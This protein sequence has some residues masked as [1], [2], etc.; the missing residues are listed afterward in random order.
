MGDGEV[1][2]PALSGRRAGQG[3]EDVAGLAIGVDSAVEVAHRHQ[4]VAQ[5]RV[6]LGEVAADRRI[7]IGRGAALGPVA[8]RVV[9]VARGGDV[10]GRLVEEPEHLQRRQPPVGML[11]RKRGVARLVVKRQRLLVV[12]DREVVAQR[13]ARG[14]AA[15]QAGGGLRKGALVEIGLQRL[16]GALVERG[17]VGE[18]G[19]GGIDGAERKLGLR[20]GP[21]LRD[22]RIGGAEAAQLFPYLDEGLSRRVQP[23]AALLFAFVRSSGLDQRAIERRQR[24]VGLADATA[25][26]SARR[27]GVTS[28]MAS[29]RRSRSGRSSLRCVAKNRSGRPLS[30]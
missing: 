26:T 12:A 24:H 1:A 5:P 22:F 2:Q 15:E 18:A 25:S 6:R 14:A 7:G 29:S 3:G 21:Q 30:T 8:E 19:A 10:S 13:R 23:A 9:G 20:L 28:A 4:R 16:A 27:S 11:R 17:G